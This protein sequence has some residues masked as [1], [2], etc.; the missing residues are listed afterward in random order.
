MA[1]TKELRRRIKSVKNTAQITKAMQ[2]VAA[3]KMRRAQSQALN[4][5]PY[6]FNLNYALRKLLPLV[7]IGSHPLLLGNES[8][9]YG[10]I[11]L[12][13]DKSLCGALN[14]NIF[15]MLTASALPS[16]TY[17]YTVGKKGRQFIAKTGKNL[18]ADFENLDVVTFRQAS[19][20]AKLV[21]GAYLN[22]EIGEAYLAYPNFISTLRQEPVKVKILPIRIED[23]MEQI[24]KEDTS[25][26]SAEFIFEPDSQT[27]L[28][29][30][31]NHFIQIKI[32]Q[33][34]LETKASEHSSRM[35]AMKNATD[36]ALDLVD[37]LS[38]TYNQTRQS[39]ITTEILDITTAQLALE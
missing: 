37:D 14:T 15:R 8:K 31:L 23:L 12:S 16:D 33:S 7:D 35:M 39:A 32:Y 21:I 19:Q 38:L 4:G 18:V 13:T 30:A 9:T 2:T 29:F 36:N 34:L 28:D 11:L 26:E 10:V 27:L 17:F 24:S 6:N 5:R 3:T 20:L 1:N 25:Q 22:K